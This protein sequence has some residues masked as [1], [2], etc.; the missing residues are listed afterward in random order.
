MF[1]A[2]LPHNLLEKLPTSLFQFDLQASRDVRIFVEKVQGIVLALQLLKPSVP[3]SDKYMKEICQTLYPDEFL[4]DCEMKV[5]TLLDSDNIDEGMS[6][7]QSMF[8]AAVH[9]ILADYVLLS[10]KKPSSLCGKTFEDDRNRMLCHAELIKSVSVIN[11]LLPVIHYHNRVKRGACCSN[12]KVKK[13]AAAG[14]KKAQNKKGHWIVENTKRVKAKLSQQ[15]FGEFEKNLGVVA[16]YE[17]LLDHAKDLSNKY[18][19]TIGTATNQDHMP[20]YSVVEGAMLKNSPSR[21]AKALARGTTFPES[22]HGKKMLAAMVDKYEHQAYLSTG[23]GEV[24][25][26]YRKRVQKAIEDDDA[27]ETFKLTCLGANP[28]I[29]QTL[30]GQVMEGTGALAQRDAFELED[31]K[32]GES[33]ERNSLC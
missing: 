17:D 23:S 4:F 27:V 18:K 25:E 19:V 21:L 22:G 28:I 5:H 32:K 29:D 12:N 30:A 16:T 3:S 31:Y 10:D 15:Q 20:A 9:K 11:D 26:N 7:E 24:A 13:T 6:R 8:W 33:K 2:T 14:K 1:E